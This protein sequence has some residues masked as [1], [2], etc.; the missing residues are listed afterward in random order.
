MEITLSQLS[1][2]IDGL[3]TEM[4]Y[5]DFDGALSKLQDMTEKQY[6]YALALWFN[7]KY[8]ELRKL[9]QSFGINKK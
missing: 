7:H 5:M 4:D 8:E 9:L 6:K 2:L 1:S 3:K